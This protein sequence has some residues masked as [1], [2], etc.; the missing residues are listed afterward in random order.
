LPTK[1]RNLN[2]EFNKLEQSIFQKEK[3]ISNKVLN[4]T[5]M[6]IANEKKATQKKN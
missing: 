3:I 2:K 6:I 1:K 4:K 5:K